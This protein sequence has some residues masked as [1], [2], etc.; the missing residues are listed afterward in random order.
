MD[1]DKYIRVYDNALDINLCRN[2]LLESKKVKMK[3]WDR[4]GRPQFNEFNITEYAESTD[5]P[6]DIWN[7]IH[8]QVIESVKKVSNDYM[9]E[10]GC[11]EQW[12]YSNALEQV[13]LKHY[14]V[15]KND[16]FDRHADVGDHSSA[17]RFLAMFFYLNDVEK[18]GE[19]EFA[20]RKIKP[21][22]GRCLAFPPMW[23]F[24]HR[25]AA[26]VTE[27]KYIIGTYLHYVDP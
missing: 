15:E 18:G 20:H 5:H 17:R 10:V 4:S 11:K 26:P 7:V 23:M 19:T 9:D 2:I 22:Q 1:L 21:V 8:N 24:P 14:E 25:G 12:P 3:R 16:R 13:R 6:D 27:D